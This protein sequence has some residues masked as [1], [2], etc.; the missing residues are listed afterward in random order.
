VPNGK[1]ETSDP[2]S[3]L[4]ILGGTFDPPHMGHLVLAECARAQL[5]ASRVVFIPAGDPYRKTEREVSSVHHRLAMIRLAI[6]DNPAF[7]IDEREMRREGP[8]YTV[9][10]LEELRAEGHEHIVLVLGADAVTDMPHW[11]H[12]GRIRELA[13]LAVAP[14]DEQQPAPPWN[15]VVDM[16]PLSISSTLIRGRVAAG[17]PI[18]YLVPDSVARYIAEHG[19]Y[20]PSAG[21]AATAP[22]L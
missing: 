6:A 18:R 14:Q 5:G 21:S 3:P 12:P 15:L 20:R 16:P 2:E 13:T 19:L 11:K 9:D 4:L 22:P 17:K 8:T 7:A 10:T 1:P